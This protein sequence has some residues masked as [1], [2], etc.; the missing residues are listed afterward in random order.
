MICTRKAVKQCV[1][2]PR[3]G[4]WEGGTQSG[5]QNA[6]SGLEMVAGPSCLATA[7]PN[8]GPQNGEVYTPARVQEENF[9]T[10]ICS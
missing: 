9:R 3:A 2:V 8:N 1:V 7:M 6:D 4:R 10:C 5:E